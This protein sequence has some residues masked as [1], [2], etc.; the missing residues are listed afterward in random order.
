MDDSF[1][2]KNQPMPFGITFN[3]GDGSG[4]CGVLRKTENGSLTFEGSA[5]DA[6]Q[7]FFNHIIRL[8]DEQMRTLEDKLRSA[9][10][11]LRTIADN[12][13]WTD[14]SVRAQHGLKRL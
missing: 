14:H 1:F 7:C 9:K 2:V 11:T 10:A 4:I 13:D 5:D 6:A 8:H 12:P 3:L